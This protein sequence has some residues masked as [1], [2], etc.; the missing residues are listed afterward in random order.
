MTPVR[1]YIQVAAGGATGGRFTLANLTDR[2][3]NIVV[4]VEQ[5]TVED[6][7]YDYRFTPSKKDWVKLST[8]QL[9]LQ[10]GKSREV[11]YE[12]KAPEGATPGGY[13]F[14]IFA[15]DMLDTDRKVR[16]GE[17]LYV[18]VKGDLKLTSYIQNASLPMV[19]FNSDI[20]FSFDINSTANSHFFTYASGKLAGLGIESK[21]DEATHLMLPGT[22]R[23]IKGTIPAPVFPGVYQATYG[24]RVDDGQTIT[25]TRYLVYA[26]LWFVALLVGA[27]LIGA[28][29][30][31][32]H[33]RTRP[34]TGS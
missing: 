34:P 6:Y 9:Q 2:E 7:T 27:G 5:F 20:P 12:I 17:A 8:N 13:Y 33:R 19:A 16:V 11:S 32:R 15:T 1:E 21:S 14:T 18:T 30:W 26:P 29:F 24:Y 4:S 23:T 10:A 31:R 22:I 25:Q 28:A 3:A